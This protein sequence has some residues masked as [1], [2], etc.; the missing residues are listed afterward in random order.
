MTLLTSSNDYETTAD[1]IAAAEA[2]SL[3]VT[4][5]KIARWQSEGLLP[6]PRQIYPPGEPGSV[7]IFP[8]GTSG[9][10]IALIIIS[11]AH[12]KAVDRGWYLW[13]LGFDVHRKY[14]E[15]VLRRAAIEKDKFLKTIADKSEAGFDGQK[16]I[17]D[18]AHE[19]LDKLVR[20]E[21][22]H[23]LAGPL[24]RKLGEDR[25]ISLLA[26]MLQT[27]LGQFLPW[28]KDTGSWDDSFLADRSIHSQAL[29]INAQKDQQTYGGL[30]SWIGEQFAGTNFTGI[31]NSVSSDQLRYIARELSLLEGLP[32]KLERLAALK[33]SK[34]MTG[35]SSETTISEQAGIIISWIIAREF[36]PIK[37]KIEQLIA[38]M[39]ANVKT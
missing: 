34:T 30:M 8:T 35:E 26:V 10:L 13:R 38:Q 12:R 25:L 29:G 28:D 31:L 9:Q 11:I 32:E 37:T 6:R 39:R 27:P 21:V 24:K 4:P 36:P 7:T 22:H 14:G 18:D 19:K 33:T 1:L 2:K 15:D 17:S 23:P 20:K 5:R 3:S 16:G